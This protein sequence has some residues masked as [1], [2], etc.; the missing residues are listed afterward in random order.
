MS[1]G[2]DFSAA[3]S[4]KALEAPPPELMP[5]CTLEG[6][7]VKWEATQNRQ[8]PP[9]PVVRIHLKANGWPD[10]VDESLRIKG[11]LTKKRFERDY[12][13]GEGDDGWYYIDQ[14]LR[15]CGITGGSDYNELLP[16]LNGAAVRFTL[17]RNSYQDKTTN[18]MKEVVNVTTVVG[19]A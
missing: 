1:T 17:K 14:L 3:L 5:D 10:E 18:D 16:Q 9:V 19:L 4:R 8:K 15:S 11:D 7:I 13:I 6:V 2:F 12:K